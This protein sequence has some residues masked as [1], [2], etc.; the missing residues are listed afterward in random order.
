M[1]DIEVKEPAIQDLEEAYFWYEMQRSGLGDELVLCFDECLE[2]LQ[3]NPFFEIRF[4]DIRILKTRRFPY[5]M[6]YRIKDNAVIVIGFIHAHRDA[7]VWQ[8]RTEE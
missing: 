5:Q 3:R 7:K 1:F 4:K 2:I 8:L 6:I